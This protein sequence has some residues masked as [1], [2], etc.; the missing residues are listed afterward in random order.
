MN[1]RVSLTA[2][3]HSIIENHL[4]R[5]DV[6]IDATIG[7]GYDTLFLAKQVGSKGMVFGFDVQ[8]KALESTR[9]RLESENTLKNTQLFHIS[10]S[11]LKEHI[12]T[13]YY[14]QL[15][16]IMFNLGYLPGADKTIITQ[17]NSTLIAL[18]QSISLLCS[19]GIITIAAYPGHTG[20][21]KETRLVK[22]WCD[23]LNSEK[24]HYEIIYS[25]ESQTAP[26]L[27]I[28]KSCL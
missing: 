21:E 16:V 17:A 4:N 20:G 12:P 9:S 15:N 2:Q 14:N 24:Y 7:N 19:T 23:Q 28:V 27:F 26:R 13:K 1:K 8:Q 6:A 25:S 3:A 22:Q 10:H 18:N 5:G 11:R